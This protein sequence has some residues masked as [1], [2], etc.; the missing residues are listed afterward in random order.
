MSDTS[1]NEDRSETFDTEKQ[2]K[3]FFEGL[4][5]IFLGHEQLMVVSQIEVDIP[6]AVKENIANFFD[7]MSTI[8]EANLNLTQGESLSEKE[9]NLVEVSLLEL[10]GV[11]EK[12]VIDMSFLNFSSRVISE[13][14]DE[15]SIPLPGLENV[16]GILVEVIETETTTTGQQELAKQLNKNIDYVL[17]VNKAIDNWN[18]ISLSIFEQIKAKHISKK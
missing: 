2:F 16:K 14:F 1:A 3:K 18:K 11:L 10:K 6:K 7:A 8:V 15:L 9:K 12:G 5:V 4:E 13:I 17:T